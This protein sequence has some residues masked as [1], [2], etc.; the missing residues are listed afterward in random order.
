M[1]DSKARRPSPH[2]KQVVQAVTIADPMSCPSHSSN[3]CFFSGGEF[4][5][6]PCNLEDGAFLG[7]VFKI[8]DNRRSGGGML[9]GIG[10]TTLWY[11]E[12]YTTIKRPLFPRPP[13]VG[14]LSG[15]VDIIAG[16]APARISTM[17]PGLSDFIRQPRVSSEARAA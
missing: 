6:Q 17:D 13:G 8:S 10:L 16:G 4:G 3:R 5:G 14:R 9:G 15:V 7:C 11:Q 2:S 1:P 12:I